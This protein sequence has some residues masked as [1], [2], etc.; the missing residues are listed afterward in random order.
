MAAL[1]CFAARGFVRK[2]STLPEVRISEPHRKAG[3]APTHVVRL[4]QLGNS[5]RADSYSK[6]VSLP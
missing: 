3:L 4:G 6:G 1:A 2:P 5:T